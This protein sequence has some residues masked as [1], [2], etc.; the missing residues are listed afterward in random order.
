MTAQ[1]VIDQTVQRLEGEWKEVCRTLDE[2]EK[3]LVNTYIGFLRQI[4]RVCLEKGWRVWFRPNRWTHWGEGG[5]GGLSVLL[6]AG[7]PEPQADLPG[8][9]QFLTGLPDNEKLGEEVT[10][11]T[12]DRIS[13]EPDRWS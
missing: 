7:E 9:I 12:L 1:E 6:P 5:F 3:V 10:S 11:T 4:A 8:E 2:Q 13:Y